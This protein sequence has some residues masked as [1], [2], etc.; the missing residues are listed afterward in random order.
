ML[1]VH[2]YDASPEDLFAGLALAESTQLHPRYA[3][4]YHGGMPWE[5]IFVDLDNGAQLMLAVIA[6]HETEQG[7]IAPVI[8]DEAADLRGADDAAPARRALGREPRGALHV[9]HLDYQTIVGRVP[10]FWVRSTASG[11]SRG[12]S[13]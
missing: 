5:L 9:E 3:Q 1:M 2:E 6:F 7:T 13:A 11:R 4:Y 12:S 8:G 10:T